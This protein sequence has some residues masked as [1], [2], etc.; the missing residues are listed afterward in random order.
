M[1]I[2]KTIDEHISLILNL[3]LAGAGAAVI[4]VLLP[5]M[6]HLQGLDGQEN[7]LAKDTSLVNGLINA[8]EKIHPDPPLITFNEASQVMQ[9]IV[10]LGNR[11]SIT[12]LSMVNQD[13][14]KLAYKKIDALPI[15]LEIQATFK[16]LGLFLGGLNDLH[17][18]IILID[19]FQMKMDAQ[20][21]DKVKSKILLY[22]CLK[23]P[24]KAPKA[25]KD[26]SASH[27]QALSFIKDYSPGKILV[28]PAEDWGSLE[29]FYV[30]AVVK[31]ISNDKK[32]KVTVKS[33]F[34]YSLSGIFWNEQKPSAIINGLVVEIGSAVGPSTVK[35]IKQ[36]EV[37]HFNGKKDIVLDLIE[38]ERT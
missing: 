14:S 38:T 28:K 13:K 10:E 32:A 29:P 3:T 37:V 21:T 36:N 18:G 26:P 35:E 6:Y 15:D 25:S 27:K 8:Q 1:N 23:S 31:N 2:L 17:K 34:V 9:E 33:E 16:Q 4:L 19:S 22:I 12:F 20:E 7:L 11:D 5:M 24:A 30:R